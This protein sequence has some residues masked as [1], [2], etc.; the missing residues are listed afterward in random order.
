MSLKLLLR[1][2][3]VGLMVLC[4]WFARESTAPH[5]PHQITQVS[6]VNALA[7][8]RYDGVMPMPERLVHAFGG[9]ILAAMR[10][11]AAN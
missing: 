4:S 8:G 2:I 7:A 6:V 11:W 10:T 3:G 9:A 5:S 1:G